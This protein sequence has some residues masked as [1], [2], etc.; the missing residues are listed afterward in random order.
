MKKILITGGAG[1]LG[2]HLC[3]R[4]IEQGNHVICLDSLFTGNEKNIQHL[5][6]N[7]NIIKNKK[8]VLIN[9][10]NQV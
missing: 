7:R 6:K 3:D 10:K 9:P 5:E 1:F 8:Q 4:L 2:S